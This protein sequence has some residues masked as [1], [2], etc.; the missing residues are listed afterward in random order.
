MPKTDPVSPKAAG[1]PDAAVQEASI[2]AVS[3]DIPLSIDDRDYLSPARILQESLGREF[4][5]TE[6]QVW[7]TRRTVAFVGLTCGAFWT[8]VYFLIASMLA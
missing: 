4:A 7:S 5:R 1:G 8:G 2:E 3:S 6:E